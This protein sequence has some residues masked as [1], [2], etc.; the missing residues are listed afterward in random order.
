M[1]NGDEILENQI[2][3]K[4]YNH[5]ISYPGVSFNSLKNLHELTDSSLRYHIHYLEKNEK[6]ISEVE[7]GIDYY[8]PHP[9][10]FK[11]PQKTQIILKSHR[12]TTEQENILNV[13]MKNPG[14]N[15]K[16]ITKLTRLNRFK[17][18]RCINSLKHLKLIKNKQVRNMT[19]YEYIPD[20]EM[21]YK[22]MKGLMVRLLK[23]E[24]DEETFIRIKKRL[25]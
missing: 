23:G 17:V 7:N 13:I 24:I 25:E 16:G 4:L 14:I 2:R 20:I 6:I 19:C 15:Q 12:L 9:S 1:L 8:Y 11:I 5:I 22:I 3:R 21:K 10:S 18:S